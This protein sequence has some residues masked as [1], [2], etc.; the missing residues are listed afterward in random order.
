M[1]IDLPLGQRQ[2]QGGLWELP[3]NGEAKVYFVEH[4]GYFN[5]AGIYLEDN[6][7]YADNAERYIYF[8]KC[9]VHL[10]RYLPWR[11]EVVHIHDWQVALV[12]ALMLQQRNEGWG[13]P[14]P[15]CLTI[16]NLAFQGIFPA[17][18]FG[19]TNLPAEFFAPDG[20]GAEYYALLNCLKGGIIFA[21]SLTT[22]SPRYAREIT[23]EELGCG[24]DGVL[25]KQAHKLTGILNGVDYS[26]WNTTRNPYLLR[27]YTIARMAGKTYNKRE[28]QRQ[29]ALPVD[30]KPRCSAPFRAWRSKKAWIS[31]W[32]PSR[33]C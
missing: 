25:R 26:E 31:N 9:V 13:T 5:R 18:A 4:D 22:V 10:A 32:A 8:S 11:A 23:T 6:L 16:H 15:T 29:V 12:P 33:R 30:E 3:Q 28:L 19:L 24:L 1:E 21:D 27:S 7:S 17:E 20:V 2:V 14:P